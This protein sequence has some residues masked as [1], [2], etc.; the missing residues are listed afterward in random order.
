MLKENPENVYLSPPYGLVI[1]YASK[2]HLLS[3]GSYKHN[4]TPGLIECPIPVASWEASDLGLKNI[5]V[6]VANSFL[7]DHENDYVMRADKVV[8]GSFVFWIDFNT[9]DK[10]VNLDSLITWLRGRIKIDALSS[11]LS[12]VIM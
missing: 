12:E 2:K 4:N 5:E 6:W 7:V 3:A 9:G 8:G 1:Y 10:G 11:V